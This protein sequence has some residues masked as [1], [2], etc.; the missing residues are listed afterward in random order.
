MDFDT[1]EIRQMEMKERKIKPPKKKSPFLTFLIVL[2]I[3]LNLAAVS[4]IVYDKGL[5]DDVI[6]KITNTESKKKKEEKKQLPLTDEN[7]ST[8]YS[9]LAPLKEKF[10]V[11]K[12]VSI[13]NIS[14]DES[15]GLGMALLREEDFSINTDQEEKSLYQLKSIVLEDAIKKILGSNYQVEKEDME[16]SFNQHFS[17]NLTGKMRLTY[18]DV[19]DIYLVDMVEDEEDIIS[20]YQTKLVNAYE[21][22]KKLYLEEKAIYLLENNGKIEIYS[23]YQLSNL[24]DEVEGDDV[25]KV[26]I[27]IDSY[28]KKANK[29][30]YTFQKNGDHYQF[31]SSKIKEK[32]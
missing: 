17:N 31:I 4:F 12:Q 32:N 16:E 30:V 14:Q 27:S 29:V 7:V 8:L 28:L 19:K 13:K 1:R 10:V 26:D 18:D 23:D 21:Q 11:S 5:L 24:I 9:Y 6:E 20:S 25:L 3:L 2:L 22:E 15:K